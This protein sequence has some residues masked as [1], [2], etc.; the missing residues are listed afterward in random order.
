MLKLLLEFGPIVVFFATYKQS[1]IFV[2]TMW[3]VSVTI[4]SLIASYM[5]DK[6]ISMPLLIS[7]GILLVS[8][9]V[10]LLSGDSSYIKMKPTLVY[11]IFASILFFGICNKKPFAKTILSHA[12][13]MDDR[14]WMTLSKRFAFYFFMM[15]IINEILWRNFSEDTWVNFKVFGALPITVLFGLFQIPFLQKHANR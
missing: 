5:I 3:M 2:A 7:G 9:S 12:F 15:A 4:I 8:G 13:S 1:D 10:T 14:Y 11:L 6:K